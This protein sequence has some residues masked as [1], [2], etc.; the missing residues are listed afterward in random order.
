MGLQSWGLV[1]GRREEV[2]R[3]GGARSWVQASGIGVYATDNV[4]VRVSDWTAARAQATV[5]EA[6][7]SHLV[8]VEAEGCF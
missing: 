2:E 7:A 3:S 1:A 8:M 4:S 5:G 6:E